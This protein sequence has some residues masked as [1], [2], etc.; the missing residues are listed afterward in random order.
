MLP[1]QLLEQPCR[2]YLCSR[3]FCVIWRIAYRV[4]AGCM[5]GMLRSVNIEQMNKEHRRESCFVFIQL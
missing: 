3:L 5:A 2:T 4:S 1:L